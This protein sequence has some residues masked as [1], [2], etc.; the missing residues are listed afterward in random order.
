M[1][2]IIAPIKRAPATGIRCGACKAT[3]V[4]HVW[5]D[6]GNLVPTGNRCPSCDGTGRGRAS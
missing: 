2:K 3:G 4:E 1:S 5:D 6:K